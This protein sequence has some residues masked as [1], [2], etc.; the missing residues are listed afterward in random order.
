M[1][2]KIKAKQMGDKFLAPGRFQGVSAPP[3]G[4]PRRTLALGANGAQ[5]QGLR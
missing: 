4:R 3:S 1:E 5:C 2:H